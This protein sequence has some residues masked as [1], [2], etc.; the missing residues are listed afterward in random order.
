MKS[1]I[2]QNAIA[3]IL[4]GGVGARLHPLTRDRAKPAVPFGGKYRVVDFTLSNCINSGVRRIFIL[5]Q[6][7]SFSLQRHTIDAWSIFSAELGEFMSHLSPQM[8]VGEDWYKGTADAVYQNLYHLEEWDAEYILILSGDHIYKMDYGHFIRYHQKKKADLTISAI[9]VDLREAHRFGVIEVDETGR[10]VGFEEKPEKPKAIPGKRGKAYVSMGVYIFNRNALI[11]TLNKDAA[12]ETSH[13][14]FGRD[15]IPF[16]YP[17]H[18]VFV[19]RFGMVGG[20]DADYWRDIGTIDAYYQANMDLASVN[21]I[22]NLYDKSWPIRT[23]EGQYPP[24][25]TVF[26][27]EDKG[28]AGKALDSIICSG[29]IIS[30]GRVE[31]SILSPGVRV[32]SYAQV[33]KSILFHN[34][35]VGMRAKVK[36]AIIDKDVRVPDGMK[37]GYDLEKDRKQFFVSDRGIVVIPKGAILTKS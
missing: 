36:R 6:Y 2:I 28:R 37:I 11:D 33:D 8:R 30:G 7:K 10:A 13:H 18:R 17:D 15:I 20:K 5:P 31:R 35:V 4:A 23:Y 34:V 12:M 16:M 19:Y 29:V 26:A 3:F 32:N 1:K 25:K 21:P 22:F 14:D 24:A 27:D 9:E